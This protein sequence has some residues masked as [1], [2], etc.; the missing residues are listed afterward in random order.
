M[1]N[2]EAILTTPGTMK[3][4]PSEVP[5]PRDNEVLIEVEY[6]GIC[7]SD[8]HGFE[9]GPLIPPKDPQQKIGLGH[10]YGGVVVRVGSNV[11]D[12]KPGDRVCGAWCARRNM[13]SLSRELLQYLPGC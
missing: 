2:S 10:E 1:K 8:V 13:S 4:F 6:V 12:F 3:I 9:F 5:K 11:T 7:G